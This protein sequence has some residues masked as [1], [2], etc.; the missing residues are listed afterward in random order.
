MCVLRCQVFLQPGLAF[1]SATI[2][3]H[4]TQGDDEC[5]REKEFHFAVTINH[6][7]FQA[8]VSD[9]Q[10]DG[11]NYVVFSVVVIARKIS[12][13]MIRNSL[14][15]RFSFHLWCLVAASESKTLNTRLNYSIT[16]IGDKHPLDVLT[17]WQCR[18]N[19]RPPSPSVLPFDHGTIL[20][21]QEKSLAVGLLHI[22]RSVNSWSHELPQALRHLELVQ[23]TIEVIPVW[24]CLT[25]FHVVY[26]DTFT[27]M[28]M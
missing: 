26:R 18:P 15:Q 14:G 28:S 17:F 19:V 22:Q 10:I 2:L 8:L 3:E 4:G 20:L 23:K 21:C 12:I 9:A 1:W 24:P 11:G 16:K 25:C 13:N 7:C 27:L 6:Q 5:R